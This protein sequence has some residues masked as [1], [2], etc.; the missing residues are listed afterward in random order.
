[1]PGH[2]SGST[3]AATGSGTEV[4]QGTPQMLAAAL[5]MVRTGSGS[6][7]A[8]W[9]L[10]LRELEACEKE[11]EEDASRGGPTRRAAGRVAASCM[12]GSSRGGPAPGSHCRGRV[13]TRAGHMD[14]SGAHLVW[15]QAVVQVRQLRIRIMAKL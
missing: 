10:C 15:R 11:R 3:W 4:G 14:V 5:N 7:S 2:S 12:G 8:T 9:E 1:M 6:E 13:V